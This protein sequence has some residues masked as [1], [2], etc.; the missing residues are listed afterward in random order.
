MV[1]DS[2]DESGDRADSKAIMS[3][4]IDQHPLPKSPTKSRT[5]LRPSWMETI[6]EDAFVPLAAPPSPRHVDKGKEHSRVSED[7][8]GRFICLKVPRNYVVSMP[9]KR[10]LDDP[11][12][13]RLSESP[14]DGGRA[15]MKFDII[16]DFFS[17]PD[18]P[19]SQGYFLQ[20]FLK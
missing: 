20:Y 9:Q 5:T 14:V 6:A 17:K 3:K 13:G 2:D 8:V 4:D 10:A 12:S 16:E 19:I 18:M 7:T 15:V 11:G 1:D